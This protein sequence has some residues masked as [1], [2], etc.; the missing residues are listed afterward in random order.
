M[1]SNQD[2]VREAA[3]REWRSNP[4]LHDE[5]SSEGAFVAFRA[6]KARGAARIFAPAATIKT[7]TAHSARVDVAAARSSVGASKPPAGTMTVLD[8]MAE[9]KKGRQGFYRKD[10]VA[11]VASRTGLSLQ[12]ASEAVAD[13]VSQRVPVA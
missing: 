7:Y 11:H 4:S 9:F 2:Q 5:F 12:D 8:A 3:A 10:L 1:S 13:T 6:A